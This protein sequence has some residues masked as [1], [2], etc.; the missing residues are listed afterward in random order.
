ML[1]LIVLRIRSAVLNRVNTEHAAWVESLRGDTDSTFSGGQALLA[2]RDL[3]LSTMATFREEAFD[4]F[5]ADELG[6]IVSVE[7]VRRN[8]AVKNSLLAAVLKVS[9]EPVVFAFDAS[10][11]SWAACTVVKTEVGSVAGSAS[12]ELGVPEVAFFAFWAHV[13]FFIVLVFLDPE[14]VRLA[15]ELDLAAVELVNTV[16]AVRTEDFVF[17]AASVAS[18][19]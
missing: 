7:I 5:L 2:A 19:F 12:S 3:A 8:I 4:A 9:G 10:L 11:L 17:S 15:F 1:D 14:V 6:S 18:V 16:R 13:V